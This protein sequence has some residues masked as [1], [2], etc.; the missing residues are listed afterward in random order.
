M[1]VYS[2]PSNW[3]IEGIT[4]E[5][6]SAY[7]LQEEISVNENVFS[8]KTLTNI[9]NPPIPFVSVSWII[10]IAEWWLLLHI[11]WFVLFFNMTNVIGHISL[12]F[13]VRWNTPVD[14]YLHSHCLRSLKNDISS[15]MRTHCVTIIIILFHMELMKR[16]YVC[17]EI[18]N[19]RKV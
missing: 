16:V 1:V 8:W 11:W 9:C 17:S 14:A 12:S 5:S 2:L 13:L 15:H 19:T 18:H 6:G 7:G 3:D 10:C 4:I